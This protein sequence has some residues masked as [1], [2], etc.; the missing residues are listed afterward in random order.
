MGRWDFVENY[1]NEWPGDQAQDSHQG[2]KLRGGGGDDRLFP[3]QRALCGKSGH[4]A[5][6]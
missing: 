3:A 2:W 6:F 5:T 4:T 1:S